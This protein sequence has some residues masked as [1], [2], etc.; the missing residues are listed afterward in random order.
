VHIPT[1]SVNHMKQG[2][3]L[4]AITDSTE[5]VRSVGDEHRQQGQPHVIKIAE[6]IPAV[7]VNHMKQ[8]QRLLTT[9]G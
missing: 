8:G 2:Q 3:Q 9:T 4:M 1:I 6:R 5:H 7:S